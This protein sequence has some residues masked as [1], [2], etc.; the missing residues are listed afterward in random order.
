M[1]VSRRKGSQAH[2]TAA[3]SQRKKRLHLGEEC[4]L[5]NSPRCTRSRAGITSHEVGKLCAQA[6]GLR[7]VLPITTTAK[8][9]A[10]AARYSIGS[11][12]SHRQ[13]G[14]Q[15]VPYRQPALTTVTCSGRLSERWSPRRGSVF[16][17]I[18]CAKQTNRKVT[19][20]VTFVFPVLACLLA[21]CACSAPACTDVAGR[22]CDPRRSRLRAL[23]RPV[24]ADCLD[25]YSAGA[26]TAAPGEASS[27]S[28]RSVQQTSGR[29]KHSGLQ[30]IWRTQTPSGK[31][32]VQEA[33]LTSARAPS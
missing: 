16:S 19:R 2:S 27:L 13:A 5:L 7:R 20:E 9:G 25:C 28:S 12:R 33:P 23:L 4:T 24:E 11:H 31:T 6:P 32:R 18:R 3:S 8:R 30:R 10:C 17:Q 26:S 15:S 22:I 21:P 1:V 29:T 14:T